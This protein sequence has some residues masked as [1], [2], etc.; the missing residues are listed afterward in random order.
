MD[1]HYFLQDAHGAYH[2]INGPTMIGR[3]P[4]CQIRLADPEV[5]RNHALLWVERKTLYIRDESTRNGTYL[6]ELPIPPNQAIALSAGS[7]LRLGNTFFTVVTL[8]PAPAQEPVAIPAPVPALQRS[9]KLSLFLILLLGGICL[10][11]LALAVGYLLLRLST[12]QSMPQILLGITILNSS[13]TC[14]LST[15]RMSAFQVKSVL[16]EERI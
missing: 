4:T 15:F 7:Q 12:A 11:L 6:S 1:T 16:F 8:L 14:Y 10:G 13:T 5:S 2:P 3:D 9:S